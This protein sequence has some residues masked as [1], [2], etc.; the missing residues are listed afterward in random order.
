MTYLRPTI[1]TFSFVSSNTDMSTTIDSFHDSVTALSTDNWQLV[2]LGRQI[3]LQKDGCKKRFVHSLQV[4]T[5]CKPLKVDSCN[6]VTWLLV[7]Y[8]NS[9]F[10]I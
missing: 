4:K 7:V 1:P 10:N 9:N 6:N 8:M 2:H 3:F 5:N